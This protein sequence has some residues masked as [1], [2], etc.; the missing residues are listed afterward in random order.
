MRLLGAAFAGLLLAGSWQALSHG[1]PGRAIAPADDHEYPL[2]PKLRWVYAPKR[3]PARVIREAEAG[4]AGWLVMHFR[5]GPFHRELEMRRTSEGVV[6]RLAGHEQVILRF[7]MRA[8]DSWS[9]DFPAHPETAE[10]TVMGSEELSILGEPRPAAKLRVVRRD[11]EGRVVSEDFEWYAP[12][13]GLVRMI[14]TEPVAGIPIRMDF[15]L[16][17]FERV[18]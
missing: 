15:T 1:P 10:C 18:R 8:G 14:F 7:P 9:M 3:G 13:L 2:A 11:R 16:V 4:A 17:A 6:G 12:G 5:C